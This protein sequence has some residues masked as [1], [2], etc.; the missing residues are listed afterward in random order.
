[1]KK[2]IRTLLTVLCVLVGILLGPV[3]LLSGNPSGRN[4]A[5]LKVSAYLEGQWPFAKNSSAMHVWL[6][7]LEWIGVLG[8]ANR[9]IEPGVVMRL[10]PA[11]LIHQSIY[12]YGT[13]EAGTWDQM[14]RFLPEG[15]TFVDVGAHHGY[16][17]LKAA[18]A[19]GP[20]GSVIS[21]EPNPA[22]I[23]RLET[24]RELSGLTPG[25]R[26]SGSRWF[27]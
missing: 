8:D 11:D 13:W 27:R 5:F 22:S 1:M 7:R 6:P 9:E 23:S 3:I 16:Y 24:N 10:N 20:S 15:G 21:I 17:S 25:C 2:S 12:L 19:M 26:A 18:R 14:K 4:E